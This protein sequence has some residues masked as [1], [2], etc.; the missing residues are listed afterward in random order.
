[1]KEAEDP[2]EEWVSQYCEGTIN[3]VDFTSLQI[4]L[5]NSPEAR[6]YL[7][8]YL[9]IDAEL[10]HLTEGESTISHEAPSLTTSS[11]VEAAKIE[12]ESAAE[13]EVPPTPVAT[14]PPS[15]WKQRRTQFVAAVCLFGLAVPIFHYFAP[16]FFS[17]PPLFAATIHGSIGTEL[18]KKGKRVDAGAGT[19]LP[20]GSYELRRG[21]LQLRHATGAITILEAPSVFNLRSLSDVYLQSG[22]F[23][24]RVPKSIAEFEIETPSSRLKNVDTQ[25][26]ATQFGILVTPEST[27]THV[28]RGKA[29][30]S[31]VNGANAH[32][33][34]ERNASSMDASTGTPTGIRYS[35]EK[36]LPYLEEPQH[37]YAQHIR[38][39]DPIAYYRMT[40]PPDGTTLMDSSLNHPGQVIW[41]DSLNPWAHGRIGGGI[42][43]TGAKTGSY[44]VVK[45]FPNPPKA[46]LSV[47]AWVKAET[48]PQWACIVSNWSENGKTAPTGQ[49]HFGLQSVDGSLAVHVRDSAGNEIG[50][51]D[52][53]PCLLYTSPSPRDV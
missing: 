48:R 41:G 24:T 44:A 19:R 39:S 26:G 46:T 8:S 30:L 29:L 51:H 3:P 17:S 49:F 37:P 18:L 47:C 53:K 34:T 28:F 40:I 13:S 21:L 42:H 38:N 35:R 43:V 20:L 11:A 45:N 4:R 32:V 9:Q 5:A 6:S 52:T 23:V 36:F 15:L 7:R 10:N 1:M 22:S 50:V 12:T 25:T 14:A 2:L 31:S 33:I 27:Q 16:S